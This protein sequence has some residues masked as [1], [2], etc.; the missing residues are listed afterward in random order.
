ME[1]LFVCYVPAMDR[2]RID[3]S[4]CPHV[5][6]LFSD[7]PSVELE[8]VPQIDHVPTLLT[9]AWPHQH[10]LWGP[11]LRP[12][13][14]RRT[15]TQRLVDLL[16]DFVT[17]SAQGLAHLVSGPVELATLAPR[18]RRRFELLRFKF[19]KSFTPE[20]VL[21]LPLNGWDTI[22][23]AV[24]AGN[25]RF[26]FVN[27]L[28]HLSAR[29]DGVA[30]GDVALE[31]LEVH[32]LDEIQH[33]NLDDAAL[34]AAGYRAV[35]D[36][37]GRLHRKCRESG[38]GLL[39]LCDHGMERV[40]R[41]IDLS[42]KLHALE[43]DPEELDFFIEGSRAT[44]WLHSG[45]AHSRVMGLLTSLEHGTALRNK[46]LKQWGIEFADNAYGDVYFVTDPG[47]SM[48]PSDFYQP[49]ANAISA[50]TDRQQRPR[51]WRPHHRGE[52]GHLPQHPSERGFMILADDAYAA[53]NE[54]ARLVDVA[55]TIVS[56]LARRVPDGMAGR[57][58][59]RDGAPPPA[60][61]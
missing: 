21:L 9:G 22:F 25:A 60:H 53:R 15:A 2:R 54:P 51:L 28:G 26:G 57:I 17:T 39:V 61:S 32:C 1:R 40:H 47:C 58:V 12:D 20:K 50:L 33:W 5:S 27:D 52:H 10:G 35:D 56:L 48:A 44:F 34:T 29:L 14:D 6:Q 45:R 18:R 31:W 36:F 59:F 16:P 55:P 19:V 8:T 46:E 7:H 37:V 13:A 11:R 4:T 3:P 38:I 30:R 49:L 23:T 43:L 42:A 41:V 24:G